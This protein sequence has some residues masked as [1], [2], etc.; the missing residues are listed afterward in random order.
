MA[1]SPGSSSIC[2][3]SKN[4][5]APARVVQW[6]MR[7]ERGSVR[8]VPGTVERAAVRRGARTHLGRDPV[9]A[10]LVEVPGAPPV[11]RRA[12][13]LEEDPDRI[14]LGHPVP[15][16]VSSRLRDGRVH[17]PVEVPSIGN[18]LERVLAAVLERET[19]AGD[20]V[21]DRLRN[22]HLRRARHRT[23]ARSD[24][25]RN[26]GDLP[27]CDFD[28]TGMDARPHLDPEGCRLDG[29]SPARSGSRA[30]ARQRLR[31]SRHPPCPP[32]SRGTERA[33]SEPS[34]GAVR[35][36]PATG[37]RRMRRGSPWMPRR[38]RRGP[39]RAP[40]RARPVRA[41]SLRGT[42]QPR[43]GPQPDRPS[44]CRQSDPGQL[45]EPRSGDVIGQIAR[46]VAPGRFRVARSIE[47]EHGHVDGRQDW[48]DVRAH[49][50]SRDRRWHSQVPPRAAEY[51]YHHS[52][53]SWSSASDGIDSR[54]SSRA[55]ARD[56]PRRSAVL[57]LGEALL[58]PLPRCLRRP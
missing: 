44:R 22:E 20:Q 4:A 43:R 11:R 47:D 31:R 55:A 32:P 46:R 36:G 8:G 21:P 7:V 56:Q 2:H 51:R 54:T 5:S 37:G 18:P 16:A 26:A 1:T 28:F 48:S 6:A 40:D 27:V 25:D 15:P 30:P 49:V 42:R 41:A 39:W 19:G 52:M 38:R 13:D 23:N 50:L 45:A 58:G 12:R 57:L 24:V 33:A 3:S 17:D 10:L 29:R 35:G 14:G 34:L 9:D 53:N